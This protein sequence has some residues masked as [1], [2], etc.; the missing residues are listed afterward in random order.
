MVGALRS[1][2][3]LTLCAWQL[4]E[5]EELDS[6][7]SGS[8]DSNDNDNTEKDVHDTHNSRDGGEASEVGDHECVVCLDQV[9]PDDVEKAD[10]S[11][12]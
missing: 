4:A 3:R 12:F 7:A 6:C 1:A 8:N 10:V 11:F 2:F 5:L 9:T